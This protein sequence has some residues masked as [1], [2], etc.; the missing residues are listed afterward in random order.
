MRDDE[1]LERL[2]RETDPGA[3][4]DREIARFR[5]RLEE[6][7]AAGESRRRWLPV[8][9]ATATV[10]A[11]GAGAIL[12]LGGPPRSEPSELEPEWVSA[13]LFPTELGDEELRDDFYPPDLET[14]A[15][16]F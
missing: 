15:S 16:L 1:L 3:M 11:A 10:L 4:D 14:L 7:I 8:S 13:V 9:A 6:R 12:V 2:R 5:V